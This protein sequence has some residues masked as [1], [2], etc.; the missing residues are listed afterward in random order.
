[1][2]ARR[3]IG[4]A[5]LVVLTAILMACQTSGRSDEPGQEAEKLTL[6]VIAVRMADALTRPEQVAHIRMHTEGNDW[7]GASFRE[8]ELWV[9]IAGQAARYEPI[10]DSSS[11][12]M[13]S[14][15]DGLY[16]HYAGLLGNFDDVDRLPPLDCLGDDLVALAA[17]IDSECL[18]FGGFFTVSVDDGAEW[19][20]AEAFAITSGGLIPGGPDEDDLADVSYTLYVDRASYLPAA[21]VAEF[22]YV[23]QQPQVIARVEVTFEVEFVSGNSLG[24]D[25]FDP[26]SLGYIESD[27]LRELDEL[28]GQVYW[29]G[30]NFPAG[31]SFPGQILDGTWSPAQLSEELRDESS[32]IGKI[33]YRPADDEF[34]GGW[35]GDGVDLHLYA[36]HASD[37]SFKPS[38]PPGKC[39]AETHDITLPEGR[40]LIWGTARGPEGACPPATHFQGRAFFETTTVSIIVSEN[41]G[42]PLDSAEGMEHVLRGL[43]LRE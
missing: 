38:L 27:F 36:V 15:A 39:I 9:D 28:D 10:R 20:G 40:A 23:H 13:I 25:F 21:A 35:F 8:G 16:R 18:F 41:T 17:L 33:Y 32:Y 42:H 37:S 43:R 1:M 4:I 22:R 5:A 14:R 6:E 11:E 7:P 31:D 19:D 12:L 29:I 30:E 24:S 26:A 2:G 3:T 34:G